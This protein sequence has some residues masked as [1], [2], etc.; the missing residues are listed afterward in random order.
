M[1]IFKLGT[2][3]KDIASGAVGMLT[4]CLINLD[5][6]CTYIFQ[7]KGLNPTNMKPVNVIVIEA[8]R[9]TGAI[10]EDI[11]IPL[12]ILGKQGEDLAS[13][14][15]GMIIGLTIHLNGCVHAEIKPKGTL[16]NTGETI[17]PVEFDIRRL[18]IPGVKI[19]TDKELKQ[20]TKKTPSPILKPLNRYS[21]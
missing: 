11:N 14:F 8:T 4:H 2:M 9:I 5:K 17:E 16:K 19:L 7:P 10:T 3:V 6:Q 20:S 18:K 1:K 12:E 15:K 21:K 13:G